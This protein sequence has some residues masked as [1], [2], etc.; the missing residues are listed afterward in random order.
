M[1]LNTSLKQI[2]YQFET[3][4]ARDQT[5]S[6]FSR[7]SERRNVISQTRIWPRDREMNR[8]SYKGSQDLRNVQSILC[9][10]SRYRYSY[11]ASIWEDMRKKCSLQII[12]GHTP[13]LLIVL[14]MSTNLLCT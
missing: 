7:I 12:P 13:D 3:D 5:T 9:E 4:C 14:M 11:L 1:V 6:K 2:V 10:N 8:G